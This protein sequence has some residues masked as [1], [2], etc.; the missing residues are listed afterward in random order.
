MSIFLL[1]NLACGRQLRLSLLRH[2]ELATSGSDGLG[3]WSTHSSRPK[4]RAT[5]PNGML[6]GRPVTRMLVST[7]EIRD[8]SSSQGAWV[9]LTLKMSAFSTV[10]HTPEVASFGPSRRKDPGRKVS[11]T[12]VLNV[13]NVKWTNGRTRHANARRPKRRKAQ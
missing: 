5:D 6:S 3:I 13:S 10:L 1:T 9:L 7:S 2:E 4:R 11:R 8:S 12:R